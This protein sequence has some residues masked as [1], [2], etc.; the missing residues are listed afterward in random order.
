MANKHYIV[1]RSLHWFA[2]F[3]IL[4]ILMNMGAQIHT[5]NYQIKGQ[6]LHRQDAIQTHALMAMGVF[7]LIILRFIWE[8]L[9]IAKLKRQPIQ[10]ECHKWFVQTIHACFYLILTGLVLT[11]LGMAVN[12][13]V[14]IHLF[15]VQVSDVAE[16]DGRFYAKMLAIHLQLITLLW[17]LIML[18]FAGV[19][20][21][22]R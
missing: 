18:H 4:F 22:R 20:Y 11:G 16:S 8:K 9:F 14:V 5:I 10:G 15:G 7:T 3:L 21:A 1:D 13:D 6:I 19:I 17:W 2:A 12:A